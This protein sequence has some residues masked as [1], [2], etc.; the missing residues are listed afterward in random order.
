MTLEELI[1][2]EEGHTFDRKSARKDPKEIG[3]A[4]IGFANAD[5]GILAV[6]IEDDKS[7]SG[8][9]DLPNREN[10][11]IEVLPKWIIPFPK[12]NFSNVEFK[13]PNGTK[14]RV[15]LINVEQGTDVHKNAKDE[16]YLRCGRETRLLK[17]DERQKLLYDKGSQT[18]ET[19]IA[20]DA[21]L[22]D[23]DL[24]L[25][26]KCGEFIGVTDPQKILLARNLAELRA[27]EL[28]IN[29]AGILLFGKNPQKWLDLA[30]VRI[31][32]YEGEE[33]KTGAAL[34]LI[35]DEKIVG[36][37]INQIESSKV[38][39]N[40]ILRDFTQLDGK[41]GK[42]ITAP[43]YPQFA[44]IE[45]LIN[46]ETHR[47][48]SLFGSDIIIKIFENRIEIISPGGFPSIV[49][50]HNIKNIHFSRNPK[51][52]RILGD[53][54]Y[55]K[56]I[57]EGVDRIF[58]EMKNAGLPEPIFK[59]N[60]MVSVKLY[61][62]IEKRRLRKDMELLSKIQHS[63]FS[64]LSK[65][66]KMAVLYTMENGRITTKECA[67]IIGKSNDTALAVLKKLIT[68][69]DPPFLSDKRD[70]PQDPKAYYE[71]N[72]TIVAEKNLTEINHNLAV[73][74]DNSIDKPISNQGK[75][76]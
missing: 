49:R 61:N 16:V 66:E 67:N 22:D 58:Q 47:E 73:S 10:E 69:Y 37:I 48:Y 1:K 63:N 70:Y 40:S 19:K 75:L 33:E 53:F 76:L 29:Y 34:N 68:K 8:F 21:T 9:K 12:Y 26:K 59:G 20:N 51:I 30:R 46:A 52:A 11:L 71:I 43:E 7:L 39:I 65:D 38:I 45:A 41:T 6:G 31:L 55:V 57:G 3:D 42:F 36:P 18:F 60:G 64:D 74:A 13:H 4:I 50:E 17:F 72:K 25:L 23:I 44:W 28:K 32:R 15:I 27:D 14:D 5:G 62:N 2:L 35:K 56:E 54:G 24:G